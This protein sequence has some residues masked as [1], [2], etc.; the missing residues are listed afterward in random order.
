MKRDVKVIGTTVNSTLLTFDNGEVVVVDTSV[1]QELAK[2]LHDEACALGK[3]SYVINTHEHADHLAGNNFFDCPII[4]SA[5]AR[6][7]M[8]S[9]EGLGHIALPS[10]SFDGSMTLHLT[11]PLKLQHFGG[12]S[13]GAAVV[14]LPE[15]K[16]LLCG[17][18]VFAGR[19]PYMGV[20][21]FSK[22][23]AAL[24]ELESWDVEQVIPGHGPVGDKSL[25]RIQREWLEG[26]VARVQQWNAEGLSIDDIFMSLVEELVPPERWHPMLK[27]AIDLA[28][29]M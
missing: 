7:V 22:W 2:Q 12:H 4:C 15:R 11:E 3:V 8:E 28:L 18:L 17:D 25:L 24:Q 23:I 1:S 16:L 6:A 9:A 13:P 20:A 10:V 19:L 5:Q 26:F 29:E 27:R 14:Y 21:D